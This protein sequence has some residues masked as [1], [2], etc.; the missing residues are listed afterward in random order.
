M[1]KTDVTKWFNGAKTKLSKH[2]PAIL[3]GVG[4]A[5]MVTTVVLAVKATPKALDLIE[6]KKK[7]EHKDELTP[8]ETVK[9][10][11][12]PYIPAAVTGVVS[13]TCLI[14]A[15]SVHARRNAGL[16]AA[17]K[18]SESTLTRYRDKVVETIGEEAEKEVRSKVNKE[19]VEEAS[20]DKP[21]VI[22][23]G[24]GEYVCYDH[25]SGRFFKSNINKIEKAVNEL[26]RRMVIGAEMYVSLNDLYNEIG[27]EET[28]M[29]DQ[30]GW[31]VDKGFI[32]I[33]PD[34]QF[35]AEGNPCLALDYLNPPTY[36]FD[37]LY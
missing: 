8:V 2:S 33:S 14:G 26:N 3:T 15:N 11:W 12:K 19:Q 34:P 22:V 18:I 13:A 24:N 4:I 35:D 9:A 32:E 5:G 31:N 7:E 28:A 1:N 37:K 36:E 29:G 30:L 21:K 10:A 25:Y 16:A 27:L 20:K 17:V 6:A 23:V